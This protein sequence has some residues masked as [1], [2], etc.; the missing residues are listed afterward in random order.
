V[1]IVFDHSIV[2]AIDKVKSAAFYA[3][4]FGF[5][6]LG[7]QPGTPFTAV[8]IDE[9]S[10]L[11]FE[12]SNE[13]DQPWAQGIHHYAFSMNSDEFDRIFQ[14]IR[15]AGISYGDRS[16]EPSNMKG[17]G[18]SPGAKGEAAS[19]YFRDPSGNLLEIRK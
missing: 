10:V 3:R 8:R 16:S 2:L 19:L 18:T 17:P 13:Q 9:R 7:E 12:N 4:I 15:A 1:A 5:K 6:N 11:F 14:R